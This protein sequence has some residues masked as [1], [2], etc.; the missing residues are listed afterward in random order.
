MMKSGG[1]STIQYKGTID[2][3]VQI[4][5]QEG[6]GGLFKGA[7]SNVFRG[8]GAALVREKCCCQVSC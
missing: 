5:Q 2:C 1:G 6:V 7:L 8:T 4:V 3:A